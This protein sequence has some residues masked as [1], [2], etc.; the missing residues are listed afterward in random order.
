[1]RTVLF[2]L[3]LLISSITSAQY[4]LSGTV[5]DNNGPVIGATVKTIDISNVS[6]V[7]DIKGYFELTV[8]YGKHKFVAFKLD[9]KRVEFEIEGPNGY[10]TELGS[11]KGGISVER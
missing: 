10:D 11:V 5:K 1:M 3:F 8:P 7:T 2:I 6:T 4:K 9:Y